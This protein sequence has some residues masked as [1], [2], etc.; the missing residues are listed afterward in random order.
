MLIQDQFTVFQ[1]LLYTKSSPTLVYV[2][3]EKHNVA[4]CLLT[5]HKNSNHQYTGST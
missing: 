5:A 4:H 1:L 2:V 3:Y